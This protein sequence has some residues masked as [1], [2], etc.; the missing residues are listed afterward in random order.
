[1]LIYI[2]II[3]MCSFIAVQILRYYTI[4]IIFIK[5]T[6]PVRVAHIIAENC[7]IQKHHTQ[8]EI[9]SYTYT[10]LIQ[11]VYISIILYQIDIGYIGRFSLVYNINKNKFPFQFLPT[12][13]VERLEETPFYHH[14]YVHLVLLRITLVKL[15][16]I[17][18][19]YIYVKFCKS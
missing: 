15:I 13:A 9:V 7:Y 16:F 3:I 17:S 11:V 1:M 19:N 6:T 2:I 12:G 18:Y 5:L 8:A 14:K 4:I 10:Y